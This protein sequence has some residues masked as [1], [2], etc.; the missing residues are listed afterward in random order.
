MMAFELDG[1]R[2]S[3]VV[4][5][6]SGVGD[7]QAVASASL[8]DADGREVGRLGVFA[9]ETGCSPA[10]TILMGDDVATAVRVDGPGFSAPLPLAPPTVV[11]VLEGG[12]V[13][14]FVWAEGFQVWSVLE[15]LAANGDWIP[16]ALLDEGGSSVD[17][18]RGVSASPDGLGVVRVASFNGRLW[19]YSDNVRV[20]VAP[21][22]AHLVIHS[23]TDGAQ[24]SV[25]QQIVLSASLAS[26]AEDPDEQPIG[27]LLSG[28]QLIANSVVVQLPAGDHRIDVRAASA[29][30]TVNITV[31]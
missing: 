17:V 22:I 3:P 15:R 16:C 31:A 12:R 7:R 21:P 4:V 8:L 27:W 9:F 19:G 26:E 25:G 11:A 18:S 23:P 20:A 10:R 30:A 29:T 1:G 2:L 24:Y 13:A 14:T 5:D 28:R 6:P